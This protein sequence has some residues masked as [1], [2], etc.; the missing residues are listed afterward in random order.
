MNILIIGAGGREHAIAVSLAKN[1][2]VEKIY[3][4][5]HNGGIKDKIYNAEID[6]DNFEELVF[7]FDLILF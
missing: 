3:I 5:K 6:H 1:P 2:N 7:L 4:S